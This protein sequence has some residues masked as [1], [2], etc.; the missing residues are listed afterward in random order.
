MLTTE[1]NLMPIYRQITNCKSFNSK[2]IPDIKY[3]PLKFET[4]KTC[5]AYAL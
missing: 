5:L 1:E 2:I 4:L 3:L